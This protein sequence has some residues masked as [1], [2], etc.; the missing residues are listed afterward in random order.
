MVVG[1]AGAQGMGT[2]HLLGCAARGEEWQF[3]LVPSQKRRC[4][5]PLAT[6]FFG[7]LAPVCLPVPGL[8]V[9]PG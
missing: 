4:L 2:D 8:S 7:P 1:E 6:Q 5:C 3:A 9:S